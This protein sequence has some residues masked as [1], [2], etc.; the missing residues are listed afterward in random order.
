MPEAQDRIIDE[1]MEQ[2]IQ[3]GPGG[4]AAVFTRL[5]N[6]VMRLERENFL[7]AR[8]Y[9][10]TDERRGY[11]NGIKPKRIDTQAGTLIVDVPRTAGSDE[12]FYPQSLECG[13]RSS[14]ALML[15]IAEMYVKG[16]STR[17][18]A[19]I[20]DKFGIDGLSSSQVSRASKLLDH[21]LEQ[22]RNRALGEVRYLIVDARYEKVRIDGIVRDATILSAIGIGPDSRRSLLGVSVTLSEAEVHWRAFLDSL[23]RRGLRGIQLITSDDHAGLGAVRRAVFGGVSWQ[24]CQFHLAQNAIHHAPSHAIRSV[25]GAELRA[26]WNAKDLEAANAE[27]RLL[28]QRYTKSAP[29][30]S[31]WLE[32]NVPE[33]LAVFSLPEQHRP[34]MR[35]SNPIERTVQQEIKRRTVK[36]RVFPSIDA[37]L[38]LVSAVLVAIDEKWAASTQPYIKWKPD[39]A[40]TV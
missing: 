16:V 5:F 35:T 33:G 25:I 23:V 13:T 4:M 6:L 29:A 31:Q 27:L 8:H 39:T 19:D 12:A 1:L 15:A 30:L 38:R 37:L 7:G 14:R 40:S 32:R 34:K 26:V 11:A 9:E 24:R 10:R 17:D 18:V 36:V 28:V 3:Q 22:W 20:L 2:L 21:D